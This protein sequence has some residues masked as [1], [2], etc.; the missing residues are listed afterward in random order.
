MH[1][2]HMSC[3]LYQIFV[4]IALLHLYITCWLPGVLHPNKSQQVQCPDGFSGGDS[5]ISPCQPSKR[6]KGTVPAHYHCLVMSDILSPKNGSNNSSVSVDCRF[7][8]WNVS[9]GLLP[10]RGAWH[11]SRF[12]MILLWCNFNIQR[13]IDYTCHVI[14]TKYL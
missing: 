8:V 7:H 3:N 6:Q 4:S 9:R 2:L 11:S 10:P 12:V 13:C 1:W 5:F 14:C